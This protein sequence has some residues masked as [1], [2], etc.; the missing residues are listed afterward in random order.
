[1][2]NVYTIPLLRHKFFVIDPAKP[3]KGLM[4][5]LS[6]QKG[7]TDEKEPRQLRMRAVGGKTDL[8]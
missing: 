8:L 2:G 1:M 7:Q 3:K 6:G 4:K 5:R